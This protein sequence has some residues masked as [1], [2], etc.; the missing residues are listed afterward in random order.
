MITQEQLMQLVHYEPTTGVFTR[1]RSHRKD[2]LGKEPGGLN[3][4]GYVQI[5]IN[6]KLYL[7]HRLAWL[8]VYGEFPINQ[9]DHIDGQKTNNK[10]TNLREA[11]NK[12]NQENTPLKSNNTT[13]FRGVHF[14]KKNNNYR[15][16][17]CHNRRQISLGSFATID[18]AINAVRT[19][20]DCLFTH[21]RTSHAA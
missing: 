7:A 19:A 11:T 12:Q 20:R 4:K 16:Y 5:R 21:H 10:I 18:L 3:T 14:N 15:A 13:G 8:Y 1:I 2:R 17:I 6:N 9:I